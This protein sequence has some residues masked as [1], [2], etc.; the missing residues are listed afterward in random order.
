MK[1]TAISSAA[2]ML[3]A[4]SHDQ[5]LDL[6]ILIAGES[7][8]KDWRI[9]VLNVETICRQQSTI[10]GKRWT[11]GPDAKPK[12]ACSMD[13]WSFLCVR[14]VCASG[15]GSIINRL[16]IIS[17]VVLVYPRRRETAA[18]WMHALLRHAIHILLADNNAPPVVELMN[19]EHARR[20][21]NV[22]ARFSPSLLSS[23][24]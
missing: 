12:M 2:P 1:R 8:A 19:T 6:A 24:A 10:Y 14:C 16:Y 21:R 17:K 5:V 3:K 15:S 9:E 11:R 20:S 23:S 4:R 22:N 7:I 18:L 13:K